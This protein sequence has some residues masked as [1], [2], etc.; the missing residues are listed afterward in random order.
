MVFF[1]DELGGDGGDFAGEIA[2]EGVEVVAVGSGSWW[3][4]VTLEFEM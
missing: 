3:R 4:I 2:E 1:G